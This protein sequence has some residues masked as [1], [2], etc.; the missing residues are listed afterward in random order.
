MARE[1]TQTA[2]F[3]NVTEIAMYRI[4]SGTIGDTTTTAAIAVGDATC[5][6]TAVTN[7]A[8]GDPVFIVGTGEA[9]ELNAIDGTPATTSNPLLYPALIAQ[10]TGARFVEAVKVSLGYPTRDGLSFTGSLDSTPIESAISRLP[11]GYVEGVAELSLNFGLLGWEIEN[12]QLMFG[13]EESVSG[14]GTEADPLQ[15]VVLG[16][17]VASAGLRCLSIKG[18]RRDNKIW[19]TIFL[20][21]THTVSGDVQMGKDTASYPVSGNCTGIIKRVWA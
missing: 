3:K 20:N 21:F 15:G 10:D 5:D 17:D 19:Q 18:T 12:L 1:N 11:I 16:S 6:L 7:F 13:A 8:D 2:V 9:F 4:A 14:S